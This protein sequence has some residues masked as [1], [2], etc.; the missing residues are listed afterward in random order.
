LPLSAGRRRLLPLFAAI[1]LCLLLSLPG[2]RE[3]RS[4]IPLRIAYSSLT[5]VHA[6]L[7]A[8][9]EHTDILA[10]R[11]ITPELLR[12][13]RGKDQE[14]ACRGGKFDVVFSCEVPAFFH[15]QQC[16][17]MRMVGCPGELGRIALLVTE[18]SPVQ[19]F[20]DLRHGIVGVEFN[21]TTHKDLL[22]WIADT[23]W[24][25]D[26]DVLV[27]RAEREQL[28]DG[29]LQGRYNA[30]M[31]WDPWVEL[32]LEQHKFRVVKERQFLSV[33]FA[34]ETVAR[35]DPEVLR[36]YF[37]AL[38]DAFRWIRE[39]RDQADQWAAEMSGYPQ[40]VVARVAAFNRNINPQTPDAPVAL[41]LDGDRLSVYRGCLEY[42]LRCRIVP[43]TWTL[44]QWVLTPHD[45][46][47]GG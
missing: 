39:H 37:A 11:G 13:V 44:E 17:R 35:T 10:R 32:F 46:P 29:L 19:Q 15:L 41:A 3:R 18:D 20:A 27:V 8:V 1:L 23:G 14:E 2:C 47:G 42:A 30:I 43:D 25:P 9:F 26:Q 16:P 28:A 34:D 22:A 7:G 33:V 5:P 38:A 40:S 24:T 21:Q 36:R 31:A 45:L 4:A 6:H 12:L